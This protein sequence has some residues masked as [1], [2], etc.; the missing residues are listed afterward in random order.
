MKFIRTTLCLAALSVA[1]GSPALADDMTLSARKRK[2]A[3]SPSVPESS[4]LPAT[5]MQPEISS[6]RTVFEVLLAEIAL[7]RG[8][9]DLACRAYADL[10]LITRD[11]RVLERA[12]EIAVFAR[13]FDLAIET[14][15][16]W[17]DVEPSSL[18]A[19]K[20]LVSALIL[21]DRLDELAPH[22][23]RMLESDKAALPGNL[24]G[25]NRMF[26]R[27]P[28]RPAVF[29]LVE[30][31]CAPFAGIAEAHYAVAVAASA[32][33]L[34]ERALSEIR[35]ALELRP[36]WETGA[37]LQAQ[38]LMRESPEE[39]IRFMQEFVE[40][41]PGARE[42]E[43]QLARALM[44]ERRYAEAKRH[45]DHLLETYPD[46]PEVVYPL[47]ILA[48]QQNDRG[49]AEAQLKHFV[50]LDVQDKSP[51]YYYLGQLAEEDKRF[52]EALAHYE[53]VVSGEQY[54]PAL[55]RRARLLSG[56]GHLDRAR[57]LLREAKTEKS[58]EPVQMVIAEAGLLREAGRVQEAFELLEKQL[59]AQPEQPELLYE[60]ALMAEKQGNLALME[61]RLRTLI[62][63][64]PESAQAYNAL[65]YS[66]ADRNM[67]L[68]E[69]RELIEKAL[70][71][72]PEDGFILDSMGW[73][74]FRQGD[75]PG[76]LTYLERSYAKRDDPE[77]AAHL[78]EVL[79]A[80]GR[81]E[82]ARRILA[83]ARKKHPSN[84]AL[85][86]IIRKLMP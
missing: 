72:A 21:A 2:P 69:A 44:S 52:E 27:N 4:G 40:R 17:I 56:Q 54:L 82:D 12:V 63:L 34:R 6:G 8:D 41:N 10:A 15:N 73:V 61:K 31:V 25:L 55:M 18:R 47:A 39:G 22:L 35:Q 29:R 77:I 11:P 64:R 42:I 45:F 33:G 37:F 74:L 16:L 30:K 9:V 75:L 79:W 76:A 49:L 5:G 66:Y 81:Q 14:A 19:Q 58:E 60:T 68:A 51:A 48:L 1:F 43:L 67:R 50:T 53:R 32:A 85:A 62:D 13:R 26:A 24:L 84:E 86:E 38:F 36:D 23:R 65:G 59:D 7:Q 3:V 20:M 80:L 83:E 28:N 71:L 57:E 78:G 70:K 46:S